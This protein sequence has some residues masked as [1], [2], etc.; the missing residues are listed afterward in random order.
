MSAV[1][2]QSTLMDVRMQGQRLA[3]RRARV[4]R[5][6]LIE[7]LLFFAALVSV[8]TTVGIV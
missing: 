8:F 2:S 1:P 4:I 3:R 6:R 5:E 7:L